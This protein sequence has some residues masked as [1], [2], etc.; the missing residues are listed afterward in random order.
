MAIIISGF[1]GAVIGSA[2]TVII[3]AIMVAADE[4]G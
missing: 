2:L 4:E 3:A 1:V